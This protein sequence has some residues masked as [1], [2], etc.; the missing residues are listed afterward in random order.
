MKNIIRFL[1]HS[2]ESIGVVC[3]NTMAV[4]IVPTM[5][6]LLPLTP[7]SGAYSYRAEQ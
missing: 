5:L 7:T 6:S 4:V 2:R 3:G 1:V